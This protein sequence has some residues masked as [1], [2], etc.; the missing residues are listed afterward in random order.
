MHMY[1]VGGGLVRNTP[2][3]SDHVFVNYFNDLTGT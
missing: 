1:S 3:Q 2:S